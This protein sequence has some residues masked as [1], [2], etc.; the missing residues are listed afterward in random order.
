MDIKAAVDVKI[1]KESKQN[2]AQK[3][4]SNEKE[5]AFA[6][7]IFFSDN[8]KKKRKHTI[9]NS[10]FEIKFIESRVISL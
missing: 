3:I 2:Y 1:R 7:G 4:L 6:E 9:S 8:V 5:E 10:T